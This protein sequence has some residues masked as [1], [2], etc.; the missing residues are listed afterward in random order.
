MG[1]EINQEFPAS[2]RTVTPLPETFGVLGK[3]VFSIGLEGF[4][5]PS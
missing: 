3:I 5:T 2:S 1:H 4:A